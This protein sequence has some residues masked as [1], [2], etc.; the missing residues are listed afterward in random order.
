MSQKIDKFRAALGN[1]IAI[2]N[3]VVRCADLLGDIDILV[4]STTL[5]A[6]QLQEII[7]FYLGERVK[8]PTIATNSGTW[9]ATFPENE[10]GIVNKQLLKDK[11]LWWEQKSGVMLPGNTA[12][13]EVVMRTVNDEEVFK[14]ILHNA[15]IRG[16]NDNVLNS[17][18]PTTSLQEELI[19]SYDWIEDVTI[20]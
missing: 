19:F 14:V 1:P 6:E 20:R 7:L 3:F 4:Q 15:F 9:S 10:Y 8:W 11:G 16:R 13:I 17:S 2:H 5:P 18:Q 12:N